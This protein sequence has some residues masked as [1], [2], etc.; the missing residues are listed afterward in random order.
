MLAIATTN[1]TQLARDAWDLARLGL[2]RI[3]VSL[4]TLK[5]DLF[6]RITRGGD[7]GRVLAGIEAAREAGL[8]TAF[9]H[10]PFEFG[11]AG[12]ADEARA[13]DFDVVSADVGDLAGKLGA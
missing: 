4:D 5:P 11:S 6:A 2:K 10:R 13:G 7:V 9:I 12:K 3:N 1:G 8:R